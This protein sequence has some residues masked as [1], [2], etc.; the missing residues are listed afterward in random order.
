MNIFTNL[1][2]EGHTVVM[3][4]HEPDIAAFAKRTVILRDGKIIEDKKKKGI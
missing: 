3:I 2:K 4:T 1:N